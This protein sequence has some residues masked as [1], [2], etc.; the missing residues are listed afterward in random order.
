MLHLS[1]CLTF[2]VYL[3]AC[4]SALSDYK[5][6]SLFVFLLVT[7]VVAIALV[8]L[9]RHGLLFAVATVLVA[10]RE[11]QFEAGNEY[12]CYSSKVLFETNLWPLSNLADSI[13]SRL[14]VD[15]PLAHDRINSTTT[16][17]SNNDNDNEDRRGLD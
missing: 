8:W 3:Y 1:D 7:G 6:G 5:S 12:W 14:P 9:T 2:S 13:K 15:Y 10:I 11:Y 4:I 16:S 17:N